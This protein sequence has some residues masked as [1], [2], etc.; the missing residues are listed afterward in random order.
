MPTEMSEVSPREFDVIVYGASGFV[1]RRAARYLAD[2]AQQ[3]SLRWAI[4]GRDHAK[5]EALAATVGNPPVFVAEGNDR[6][7]LDALAARTRVI[8]AMAGPF[9]LYADKLVYACVAAN[10]HYADITGETPW[11]KSLID[12][13]HD[14]AAAGGTRIVPC[15][16]FDSAPSDLGAYLCAQAARAR[17][18]ECMT[19]KGFFQMSGGLNG[20][21]LATLMMIGSDPE[22][23]GMMRDPELLNPDDI[24][25][26]K[27]GALRDP[28]IASFDADITAWIA[29]FPMGP[30]NTRV[31]R[32]SAALYEQWGESY[33]KMFGY[34]EYMAFPGPF[35]ATTA[36]TVAA[37]TMLAQNTIAFGSTRSL[38]QPL[39]PKPGTG[40]SEAAIRDG[41]FRCEFVGRTSDGQK[42][43]A[44]V[45]DRGDPG[46]AATVKFACE[47]ALALAGDAAALPGGAGRGGVLTPAS[48]L[49][50]V[51]VQRL[52]AAGMTLEVPVGK[53]AAAT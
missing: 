41:W 10:T 24:R 50:D 31:V 48:A 20:G 53:G 43:R 25:A 47:A 9:A 51:L 30:I 13:H 18:T 29:P 33:G 44:L 19:V 27:T 35:G 5:L 2:H 3:A 15:C 22:M 40:P 52:R 4:A 8:L 39:I 17:G 12:R 36:A 28:T 14:T 23:N 1:G 26:A 21:T 38:L 49:G 46:N 42:I 6:A 37:G 11:V 7:A 16:G 32:R 34:Q 45:S